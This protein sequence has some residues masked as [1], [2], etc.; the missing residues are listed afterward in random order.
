M[1]AAGAGRMLF[2]T[3]PASTTSINHAVA[4]RTLP[5]NESAVA[6]FASSTIPNYYALL[7]TCCFSPSIWKPP[8]GGHT[9][10]CNITKTFPNFRAFRSSSSTWRTSPIQF[11]PSTLPR[12]GEVYRPQTLSPLDT[13]RTKFVWSSFHSLFP[14]AS[15][16]S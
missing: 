10:D 8:A 14:S 9:P 3:T 4:G 15:S 2:T 11:G 5:R 13:Q 12:L 7:T 6:P 1:C 16:S